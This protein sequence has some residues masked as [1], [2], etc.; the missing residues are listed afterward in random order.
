MERIR[1]LLRPP[2]RARFLPYLLFVVPIYLGGMFGEDSYYWV[3]LG[4]TLLGALLVWIA[5]PLVAEMRFAFS[6]EAVV[7]GI[8][9]FV[10][11][12]GI[13]PFYGNTFE[14]ISRLGGWTGIKLPA[15]FA[16][17]PP[18]WNPFVQYGDRAPMAWFFVVTRILG[19]TL[20]V[21]ALEEVFFRS[22]LYRWIVKPD[23]DAVPLNYFRW[24]PFLI[25]A[26]FFGSIHAQWLAG[27][28]CAFAYQW[29]VIRKNRLG[30]AMTAHAITNCLLGVYVVWKGAWQ[31][32]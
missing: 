12:V 13:D 3:Y 26:A 31:F 30:D 1:Q 6:R 7:T 19:S 9:V 2:D 11:W 17:A 15:G 22:F 10:M 28:L 20:V 23:F 8:A 18:P 4:R 21:P 29:L 5:W 16:H 32:W 24:S 27:I 25:T 14:L